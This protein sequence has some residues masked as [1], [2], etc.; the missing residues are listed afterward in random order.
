MMLVEGRRT[1]NY[2]ET[3]RTSSGNSNENKSVMHEG[4]QS[5]IEATIWFLLQ[6]FD[7]LNHGF[8]CGWKQW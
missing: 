4:I 8:I 6:S 3:M 7:V 2:H 1:S 5:Y